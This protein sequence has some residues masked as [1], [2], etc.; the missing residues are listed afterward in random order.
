MKILFLRNEEQEV[1]KL[2]KLIIRKLQRDRTGVVS[3]FLGFVKIFMTIL[4]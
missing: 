3:F 1:N 2:C 4:H